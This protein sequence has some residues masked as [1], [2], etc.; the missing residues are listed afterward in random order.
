MATKPRSVPRRAAR[1]LIRAARLTKALAEAK[2]FYRSYVSKTAFAHTVER[3]ATTEASAGVAI[4]ALFPRG[5]LLESVTRLISTLVAE[6]YLVIAV[7]NKSRQSPE[8]LAALAKLNITLLSRP[9]VGRDF[10]AYKVGYLFAE[11]H[12]LLTSAANLIF[13]NDSVYYGPRSQD[14]LAELLKE[15]HPWTA[16][17]VNHQHHTHAQSFFLRFSNE[18]FSLPAFRTFWRTYYPSEAREHSI[19]K[20]EIKLS[21]TL[22]ELGH[23]PHA[24]VSVDRILS[25]PL[26]GDFKEGERHA[27]RRFSGQAGLTQLSLERREIEALMRAQFYNANGTH[28]HGLLAS[29]VLGTPLKLDLSPAWVTQ[30]GLYET[31]IALGCSAEEATTALAFILK[32]PGKRLA[33]T[34]PTAA[35]DGLREQP[36][37]VRPSLHEVMTLLHRTLEPRAYIEV[38]VFKGD[39][40]KLANCPAIGIDPAPQVSQPLPSTAHVVTTTSDDFFA[41]PRPLEQVFS[42]GAP[43]RSDGERF[44]ELAL[45]DGMHHAEFAL[46][47]FINIERNSAPWS[48]IVFDDALPENHEQALRSRA[49]E[50]W[51]GDVFRVEQ[52]LK[53]YRPDLVTVRVDAYTG[54]LLVF[55][56][57]HLNR[58]LTNDYDRIVAEMVQPDPQVVPDEVLER[59]G[60]ISLETLIA[61][62]LLEVV[63]TARERRA[64]SEWVA[65]EVRA[66]LSVL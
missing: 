23:A 51:T 44:A 24:F 29:R 33:A 64:S 21:A 50:A 2:R 11:E 53:K 22:I 9:N 10:G 61:S 63:R 46:R 3:T 27:I 49:T 5:P 59:R 20:G 17:F 34:T 26:F 39:S 55:A 14:H 58:R 18:L 66:R 42:S 38:G 54:A 31:L 35:T 13:A 28:A 40:L 41:K 4:V 6:Q 62:G 45:I 16:M 52:V 1:A 48:V 25:H 8:W 32:S 57:H 36:A 65:R 56:P 47:D 19:H 60:A 7:V 37:S 43:R 12:G 30:E 15:E